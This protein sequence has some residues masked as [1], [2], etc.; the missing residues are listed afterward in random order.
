MSS[1]SDDYDREQI[2][3]DE[4]NRSRTHGPPLNLKPKLSKTTSQATEE[5]AVRAGIPA[6]YSIKHWDPTELPLILLGS[7][8]DANSL[9]RWIYDWT[10]FHHGA[11][12]PMADMAGELWLLLIKLSGKM[13]R[14]EEHVNRI[15]NHDKRETVEDF[16]VSGHRLWDK[17]K[18][19][20]KDSERFM[21]KAAKHDAK[22][23]MGKKAGTEFVDSIFGRDRHLDST[24]QI[25][26]QIRLWNMRF[27][28]NCKDTLFPSAA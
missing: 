9:G 26:N 15:H 21:L 19:L 16:L 24:E 2:L 8:F 13:K 7:V 20:L 14:A 11:S 27:D 17:F 25:M 5:D 10:V 22:K 18:Y 4:T 1:T 12:T 3:D 23:T 6:G 28:V